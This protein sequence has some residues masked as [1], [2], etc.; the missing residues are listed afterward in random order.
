MRP[1]R[2]IEAQDKPIGLSVQNVVDEGT[3]CCGS[4]GGD[5]RRA[6]GVRMMRRWMRVM[7]KTKIK[8]NEKTDQ[9]MY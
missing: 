6:Y 1:K 8:K 2:K 7:I 9:I 3:H 4:G 5:G